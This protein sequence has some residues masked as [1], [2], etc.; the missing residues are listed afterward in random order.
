M[1][2]VWLMIIVFVGYYLYRGELPTAI[3]SDPLKTLN[4]RLA[5]GDISLEEYQQIKQL[6][7]ES[8]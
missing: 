7:E 4:K 1:I 2:L 5:N 8:K 3:N 6:L